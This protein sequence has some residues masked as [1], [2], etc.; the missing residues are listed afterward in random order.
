MMTG[1]GGEFKGASNAEPSTLLKLKYETP[2]KNSK[3]VK[4]VCFHPEM[5]WVIVALHSGLVQIWDYDH[6][7]MYDEYVAH[8]GPCRAVD[9][10]PN[11]PIFCTGGDDHLV[12]VFNYKKKQLLFDLSGHLDYIRSVQFHT[13]YPWIVSASDDHMITIWNWQSRCSVAVL[14]GHNHYVMSARFHPTEDFIVSA[15]LDTTVRMWD[16][17]KLRERSRSHVG[18]R[19]RYA[20]PD[21]Y[22]VHFVMTGHAK[23]VNWAEFHPTM[24]YVVSGGDDKQV[25]VFQYTSADWSLKATYKSHFSNVGM[26]SFHPS[27]GY[28]VS[29]S[30]DNTVRV[31]PG[32]DGDSYMSDPLVVHRK[33]NNRFWAVSCHPTRN[34]IAVGHDSGTQVM[35]L[36][37]ERV[38]A[39]A[40]GG[41]DSR[42]FVVR[43]YWI[44]IQ[45]FD[46]SSVQQ[47]LVKVPPAIYQDNTSSVDGS[48]RSLKVNLLN[49]ALSS[50]IVSYMRDGDDCAGPFLVVTIEPGVNVQ[51]TQ[52]QR[53]G[54]GAAFVTRNRIAVL[55]SPTSIGVYDTNMSPSKKI[56]LPSSFHRLYFAGA[57]RV[58]LREEFT[59]KLFDLVGRQ[60]LGEITM[61]PQTKVQDI[62]FERESSLFAILVSGQ[63]LGTTVIIAQIREDVEDV[64]KL[65]KLS[66][67]HDAMRIK[68]GVFNESGAFI[69]STYK[70]TKYILPWGDHGVTQSWEDVIYIHRVSKGS[71]CYL[72]RTSGCI[73]KS[74]LDCTEMNFK[75]A[76]HFGKLD[77]VAH[78][79]KNSQL[80][81]SAILG[82]LKRVGYPEVALS[83]VDEPLARFNLALSYGNIAEAK[84]CADI[85]DRPSLWSRLAESAILHGK[86]ADAE[87][88]Y[89]RQKD[90][91]K[92]LHLYLLTGNL[93]NM[94][95]L[96]GVFNKLGDSS[97]LFFLGLLTGASKER[98]KVL[99][100][101]G[102]NGLAE[103]VKPVLTMFSCMREPCA[104]ESWPIKF[105][106]T[107]C[108]TAA[109]GP[110]QL[111]FEEALEMT[112][113]VADVQATGGSFDEYG[114]EDDGFDDL[115]DELELESVPLKKDV[116][117]SRTVEA[118]EGTN[119]TLY[120]NPP[121]QQEWLRAQPRNA[122]VAVQ[123]GAFASALELLRKN[124]GVKNTNPYLPLFE[125]VLMTSNVYTVLPG[126]ISVVLSSSA[127]NQPRSELPYICLDEVE[128]QTTSTGQLFSDSKFEECIVCGQRALVI[129]SILLSSD[130]TSNDKE[131]MKECRD[132]VRDLILAARMESAKVDAELK[133]VLK[134]T[135]L[136]T[137]A[138]SLPNK[139]MTP[140][141]KTAI[142]TQYKAGN[143]LYSA[144]L[145][146]RVI[147]ESEQN[148]RVPPPTI[149]RVLSTNESFASNKHDLE[150]NTIDPHM[151]VCCK[152][153]SALA[154]GLNPSL[155]CDQA[156]ICPLC[157]ARAHP[158]YKGQ[159]CDVCNVAELGLE[160]LLSY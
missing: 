12:K 135:L 52:N 100:S 129:C 66:T 98:V 142:T 110:S 71:V 122:I 65:Q 43:N 159:L 63:K 55:E 58:F 14:T 84:R 114:L 39:H 49:P 108:D 124:V 143:Y 113:E 35:K 149:V 57:N 160:T 31:F 152:S 61:P 106:P 45:D 44:T 86:Y 64:Q 60:F 53:T 8:S 85:L 157:D 68:S 47:S 4:A 27:T 107:K 137:G 150:I 82:H 97:S 46:Q 19:S 9:F 21:D 91:G 67:H 70:H 89:Q 38:P 134:I 41:G 151:A 145:C 80:C 40:P 119:D 24:P 99:N 20:L 13:E 76:L 95:R 79:V 94:K 22:K 72:E 121:P 155:T 147:R 11:Q 148:N 133:D 81:G 73:R 42:L 34:L 1:Y 59:L 48:I 104:A 154:G 26:V 128:R 16:I 6:A 125:S 25:L 3:R 123:S 116:M 112:V 56:E 138:L 115:L 109:I 118:I 69:Y 78:Y 158:Q 54:Y 101:L 103:H 62:I 105:V 83:F 131:L 146:R 10:H 126:G 18:G 132:L 17:R 88:A 5:S 29:V 7:V 90:F 87:A 36:N 51:A 127:D 140:L 156:V 32:V 50:F 102:M 93:K 120:E 15:S 153:L 139:Y 141:L 92:L 96:M 28:I 111:D 33:D 136:E 77:K 37:R 30:E 23:G 75:I 74:L 144:E 117:Q 130:P 2:S